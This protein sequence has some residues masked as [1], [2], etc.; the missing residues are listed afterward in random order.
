MEFTLEN[1]TK[2][3]WYVLDMRGLDAWYNVDDEPWVICRWNDF[4]ARWTDL[5][6]EISEQTTDNNGV[7]IPHS[8]EPLAFDL[9]T[10]GVT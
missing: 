2:P 6:Y 3:G 8:V 10:Q 4:Y 5:I 1:P 7:V 9:P